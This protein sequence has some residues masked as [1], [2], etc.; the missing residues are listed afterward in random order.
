M[1]IHF[2]LVYCVPITYFDFSVYLGNS[3]H[4]KL[5]RRKPYDSPHA[6]LTSGETDEEV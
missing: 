3:R 1:F 2:P 5:T 4:A 6:N